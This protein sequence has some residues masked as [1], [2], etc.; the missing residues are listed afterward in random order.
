MH[1]RNCLLAAMGLLL[2]SSG[3][4]QAGLS[5][6]NKCAR[7][8]SIARGTYQYCFSRIREASGAELCLATYQAR[9]AKLNMI[10]G[11]TCTG[12]RWVDNLDGSVTDNLTGLVWEKKANFDGVA[13]LADPHDADNA[14]SWT[15]D[16]ADATDEDG[17]VFTDFLAALNAGGGFAG[18]NGWRLPTPEEMF[19]L[20]VL[21]DGTCMTPPCVDPVVGPTAIENNALYWTSVTQQG[22]PAW[23]LAVERQPSAFSSASKTGVFHVRAVRSGFSVF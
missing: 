7:G 9:W 2:V 8:R 12:A 5:P 22:N 17:T 16:D 4:A 10:T 15:D 3:I 23:G 13:N 19:T 14:Y 21:Q 11:T 20:F 18:S 1:R 6:E